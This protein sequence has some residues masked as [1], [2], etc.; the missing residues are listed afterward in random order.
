MITSSGIRVAPETETV[1]TSRDLAVAMGRITRYGGAVW[2]PLMTHSI[3]V[4]E[5]V[6]RDLRRRGGLDQPTRKETWAWA[7]LHDAHECVTGEVVRPWKTGDMRKLQRGLDERLARA[8]GVDL[9]LVDAELVHRMDERALCLEAEILGLPG[10]REVYVKHGLGGSADGY[11][12]LDFAE[13]VFVERLFTSVFYAAGITTVAS[14]PGVLLLEIILEAV[15]AGKWADALQTWDANVGN[16][17][18]AAWRTA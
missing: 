18:P 2:C 13:G 4:A 16:F 6:L 3:L 9:A 15:K 11:P 5:L 17:R 1:P 8:Y 14:G 12:S 7:L 10:F